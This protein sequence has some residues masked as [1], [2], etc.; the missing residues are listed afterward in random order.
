MKNLFPILFCFLFFLLF[1]SSAQA[2]QAGP[3]ADKETDSRKLHF[4]I[5]YDLGEAMFNSFQSLSGEVGVSLPNRH[6]IR[7]VH[8]NV[9]LT[10]QHLSSDFVATVDGDNVEGKMLGFELFYS[11]PLFQWREGDQGFY[12]S[13][14]LGVYNNQYWHTELDERLDHT[15]GTAG[16]EL[17]FREVNPFKTQGAFK[18][19]Y[20]T[21]SLPFRFHFSPHDK[22]QLGNTTISSNAFDNNIWL[23]IGYEF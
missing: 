22:T 19:L 5:G 17:S 11:Y 3:V 13:P 23:F 18:G 8:M 2:Q 6:L 10:E 21:V 7:L 4:F 9:N 12:V 15:S 16:F 20:Y 1:S 14:S